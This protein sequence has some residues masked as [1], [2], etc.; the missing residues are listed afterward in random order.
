MSSYMAPF[1]LYTR[2][3]QYVD[4]DQLVDR[5]GS[6]SRSR[7][8]KKMSAYGSSRSDGSQPDDIWTSVT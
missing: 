8:I 4:R 5:R 3:A 7:D 2:G 1:I 6:V